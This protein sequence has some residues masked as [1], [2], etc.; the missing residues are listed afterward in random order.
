MTRNLMFAALVLPLIHCAPTTELDSDPVALASWDAELPVDVAAPPIAMDWHVPTAILGSTMHIRVFDGPP[1]STV[2]LLGSPNVGANPVCPP[3]LGGD[4]LQ[5]GAPLAILDLA[6]SDANGD[7]SF[8]LP[9]APNF[10]YDRIEVQAVALSP[11]GVFATDDWTAHIIDAPTSFGIDEVRLGAAP[12]DVV[13]VTGVVTGAAAFGF[14]VQQPGAQSFGGIWVYTGFNRAM[15]TPGDV[16]DVVGTYADY[17]N[18]GVNTA[19]ELTLAELNMADTVGG[20]W[21]FLDVAPLPAPVDVT[22]GDLA[23]PEDWEAVESMLVRV[24][25]PLGLSVI[26]DPALNFGEFQAYGSTGW[27]VVDQLMY[28]FPLDHPGFGI[29][30]QLEAVTGVVHFSW[31]TH[32]IAPRGADDV[33]GYL[34]ATPAP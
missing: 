25:D 23:V 19:P 21:T 7:A 27:V 33:E 14:S 11:Q 34:P 20:G 24:S 26:S 18:Y 22:P 10:P 2:Y 6:S 28:D 3:Q 1:S 5:I 32:K 16:V 13:S 12:G 30:D 31:G 15:P 9:L 29:G 17:D 8:A 4:C